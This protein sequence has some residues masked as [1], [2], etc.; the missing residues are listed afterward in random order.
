MLFHHSDKV[1]VQDEF[2]LGL[3]PSNH[4]GQSGLLG[5]QLTKKKRNENEGS[6]KSE[7]PPRC[8]VIV[9]W[10]RLNSLLRHKKIDFCWKYSKLMGLQEPTEFFVVPKNSWWPPKCFGSPFFQEVLSNTWRESEGF[11]NWGI[12]PWECQIHQNAKDDHLNGEDE[13]LR[14]STKKSG[15]ALFFWGGKVKVVEEEVFL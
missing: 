3:C 9:P 8:E 11:Q 15:D 13:V 12:Q 14:C 6:D 4:R 7:N 5:L 10:A 1:L 2:S